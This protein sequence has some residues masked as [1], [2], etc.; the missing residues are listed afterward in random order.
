M[1]Q[2]SMFCLFSSDSFFLAGI[3]KNNSE[4]GIYGMACVFGSILITFSSALI[5]Y[6]IPK[7]NE[8]LSQKI[9]DYARI[10]K[11]FLVYTGLMFFAFAS[12]L[13]SVP[14]IYHFFIN[15]NYWPGIRYFYFLSS[16]YFFWAITTFLYTF[17]LYFKHKKILL[18]LACLSLVISLFSNYFL[19]Q[20]FGSRGAC[21]SVCCT[22]FIV[23]L[24]TIISTKKY[25]KPILHSAEA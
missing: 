2:L 16:G 13:L 14:L 20:F 24:F 9:I 19:I 17:L 1:M 21:V 25:W 23:M 12:L 4:V 22:Y 8:I 3:T 5:Q 18:I 7:L 10:K 6:M 15:N 11:Q